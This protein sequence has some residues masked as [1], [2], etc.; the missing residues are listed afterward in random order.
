[1]KTLS[2]PTATNNEDIGILAIAID[3][4][5]RL[6]FS[7]PKRNHLDSGISPVEMQVFKGNPSSALDRIGT[8]HAEANQLKEHTSAFHLAVCYKGSRRTSGVN[9]LTM[10]CHAS[11][12]HMN[13]PCQSLSSRPE[14]T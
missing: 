2:Y 9:A 3:L 12:L 6:E 4:I 13:R 7:E 5:L 8:K 11:L 1:M 10:V 14:Q